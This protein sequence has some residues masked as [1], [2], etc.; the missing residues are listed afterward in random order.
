MTKHCPIK[1]ECFY[2]A[3]ISLPCRSVTTITDIFIGRH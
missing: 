1:T 2:R 3:K